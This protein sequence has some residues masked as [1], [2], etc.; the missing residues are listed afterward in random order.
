MTAFDVLYTCEK[1]LRY[2]HDTRLVK[3]MISSR[4]LPKISPPVTKL[5]LQVHPTR[6]GLMWG[7]DL[8]G[9]TLKVW[10]ERGSIEILDDL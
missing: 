3:S 4:G 5:I 1:G 10:R 9:Q 6:A 7:M 8:R 2:N